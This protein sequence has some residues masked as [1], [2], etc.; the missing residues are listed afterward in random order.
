MGWANL[1]KSLRFIPLLLLALFSL[2]GT[3]PSEPSKEISPAKSPWIAP[4]LTTTIRS[5]KVGLPDAQETGEGTSVNE[6]VAF[7]EDY[8]Q[9]V[10]EYAN[11]GYSYVKGDWNDL[12]A[13]LKNGTIDVLLDVTKTDER[14]KDFDFSSESMGTE[15][16]CLYGKNETDISYND[17]AGF[18]NK[19]VG[20][21]DGS[22]NVDALQT[23]ADQNGFSFTR[24]AYAN[25]AA[26]FTGLDAGEV[27][28]AVT[29]NYF[30]IPSPHS[31]LAKCMPSSVYIAT[32]KA[33][34]QLKQE[35]D[36]A[37]GLLFNYNPGFNSDL[38]E[39][40]FGK[41]LSLTAFTREEKAYIAEKKT[42]IVFYEKS[43]APFE[44]L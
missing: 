10:A 38:Y 5:V 41:S 3:S 24:K 17:F 14:A 4:L 6:N 36:D 37:M 18:N 33:Q 13:E 9:A 43:W 2:S 22:L 42:I 26:I 1:K 16:V 31:L 23:Y 19:V 32:N 21:E 28:F 34:P 12:L 8:V 11:W 35:V 30:T 7:T 29:T 15:M 39:Y 40:H 20:Y 27:D 44:Y 25:N